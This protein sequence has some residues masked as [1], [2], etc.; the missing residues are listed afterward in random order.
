MTTAIGGLDLKIQGGKQA[1]VT[2]ILYP[3]ENAEDINKIR[4][5]KPYVLENI[6]IQAIDTVQDAIREC[7]VYPSGKTYNDYFSHL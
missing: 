1:G 2:H 6:H 7:F 5:K 3:S 4:V